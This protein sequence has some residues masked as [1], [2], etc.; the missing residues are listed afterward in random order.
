MAQVLVAD[1]DAFFDGRWPQGF[2]RLDDP[3]G[4]LERAGAAARFEDRPTAERTTAWKQWIPY[5]L[6]RCGDWRQPRAPQPDDDRGLLVVQRTRGQTERRLHGSM[7]V[8]LGGHVEPVDDGGEPLRQQN[9]SA[10]FTA[11]LMRELHEELHLGE[12]PPTWTPRLLGLINDDSTDVGSV[13]AG[14]AYC[15]DVPLPLERARREIGIR[16]IS[17]MHGT[18]TSL[19]EFAELWQTRVQFESWSQILIQAVVVGAMG[20]R[21]WRGPTSVEDRRGLEA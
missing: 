21:S 4:F 9:A 10:F 14:L 15:V 17:K 12:Q 19:V 6:L 13:H 16:E 7:S 8:G 11:A 2:H 5:C 18:F 1:R 20:G 3:E